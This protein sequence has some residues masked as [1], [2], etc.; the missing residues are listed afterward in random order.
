VLFRVTFDTFRSN[1]TLAE[2]CFGPSTLVVACD[3]PDQLVEAASLVHG[4]LT[5]SI[6][7]G[8]H[9]A[10]LAGDLQRALERRV[11]RLI[12]NGVPTGVE[13]CAS[14]VHG[15]PY[16]ATNQPHSTAVGPMSIERW[17]RPVCYQNA[18]AQMLPPELREE[19]PRALTRR[20]NG[21]LTPP[22]TPE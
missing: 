15:G 8:G 12:Y 11:G 9:D 22:G 7:A 2:E 6:F 20:V 14:M 21:V 13:V 17:C 1:P 5:G 19:N 18:P 16:P 10:A 4:S 3:N